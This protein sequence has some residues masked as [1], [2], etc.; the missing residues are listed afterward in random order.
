MKRGL[1]R[2]AFNEAAALLEAEMSSVELQC[3]MDLPEDDAEDVREYIR[4]E[5]VQLL[6]K[7]EARLVPRTR[8][9]K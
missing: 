5:I 4:V 8:I 3:D 7:H 6:R 1:K 9:R 2:Q